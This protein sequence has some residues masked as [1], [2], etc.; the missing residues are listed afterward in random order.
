MIVLLYSSCSETVKSKF[1]NYDEMIKSESYS[2]GWISGVVPENAYNIYEEHNLDSNKIFIK[3]NYQ[4]K[5]NVKNVIS[6]NRNEILKKYELDLYKYIVD[7]NRFDKNKI[8]IFN[9]EDKKNQKIMQ[10]GTL[11]I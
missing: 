3:F 5:L 2:N 9:Y 11:I 1:N 8:D 10:V 4:G 6:L 7:K